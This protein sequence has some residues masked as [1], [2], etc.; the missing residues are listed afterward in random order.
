[1]RRHRDGAAHAVIFSCIYSKP[2]L[3]VNYDPKVLSFC[4][5][6]GMEDYVIGLAS[7]DKKKITEQFDLLMKNKNQLQKRSAKRQRQN[8]SLHSLTQNARTRC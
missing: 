6:M 8:A 3:A 2:F 7:F 5:E 1:M 4:I